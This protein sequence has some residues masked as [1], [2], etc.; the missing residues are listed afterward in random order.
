MTASPDAPRLAAVLG[1]PIH[2][3]LSPLVHR[4]WAAR[5]GANA[6]YIPLAVAPDY[7]SFAR[8]CDALRALGFSGCNVTLPHKEHALRYATT[9]APRAAKAGAAN[10]LTFAADGAHADNSDIAGFAGA[11]RDAAPG[12]EPGRAVVLGAGGAARGVVLA[13]AEMAF[14]PIVVVNRS[15][16]RAETVAALAA[17]AAPLDWADR[18]EPLDGARLVV[19]A[20]SLGMKGQP[21][22][23]LSL[24]RL[25][26]EA[27]VAD[28]VYAPLETPLLRAARA[29]GQRTA[30]GLAMLM[31]QA[32]FGYRAWLGTEAKVD[33]GLRRLLEEAL[34]R[35][36]G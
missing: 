29:R 23:E 34:T 15:R 12:L 21:P 16:E 25:S 24:A 32:T 28:I 35:R 20:T 5:E 6:H 4:T 36:G 10:M 33:A 18:E 3:S 1:W 27:V 2:H 14:A 31:H 13:L 9:S 8:A 26:G 17:Q 22:L 19:N 7:D 11:L 30:D